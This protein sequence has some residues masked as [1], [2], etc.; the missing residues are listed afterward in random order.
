MADIQTTVKTALAGIGVPVFLGTWQGTTAAPAQYITY[1]ARHHPTLYGDN[2]ATEH[3]YTVY[4]EIWSETSYLTLKGTV[5][6][7][8]EG[9]DFNI[10]E[11]VDTADPDINHLSMT[12]Y[13][14]V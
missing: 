8:M 13:G 4:V 10:V 7:A 5:T 1:T 12:W 6:T 2:A 9:I 14:V 11:E 3:E